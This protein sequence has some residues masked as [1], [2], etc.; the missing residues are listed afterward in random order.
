MRF[1]FV[2]GGIL[3][4]S[5]SVAVLAQD[6][7][8][9]IGFV[10]D[11]GTATAYR[12]NDVK[13]LCTPLVTEE[14]VHGSKG[15]DKACPDRI[16]GERVEVFGLFNRATNSIQAKRVE[17][18]HPK[19]LSVVGFALI[20]RV[21]Q[22]PANGTVLVRADGYPLS[23]TAAT[24]LSY[25]GNLKHSLVSAQTNTWIRY[26]GIL[27]SDG[28]VT[29]NTAALFPNVIDKREEDLRT[30]NEFDA[31]GVREEQR[32]GSMNKF[33]RGLNGKRIPAYDDEEMQQRIRSIGE[34]LV[35]AYQRALPADDPSKI[36]FRFQLVD[37]PKLNDELS[38]PNG[39][40]LMPYQV[41]TR[42]GDSDSRVAAVLASGIAEVLGKQAL[43]QASAFRGIQATELIGDGLGFI[44]PGA[45][46]VTGIAGYGSAKTVK[47]HGVEQSDR[48]ALALMHDA[49]FDLG[50]APLAWW[51]LAERSG[52][53]LA[54][55]GLPERTTDDYGIL[56]RVWGGQSAPVAIDATPAN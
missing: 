5:A 49:G 21:L 14:V 46:I 27:R 31:A 36:N 16:L 37:Q 41:L 26:R 18:E 24:T 53:T 51:T 25:A 47:R 30:R 2:A 28:I 52:Q 20:D 15:G 38:F 42:L 54:E 45:S 32:Q 50:Q 43:R 39:I 13:V 12:V 6:S 7:P 34:R 3:A 40:I 1:A 35:P 55:T 22:A 29:A 8:A 9:L 4:I 56:A 17:S 48:V 44:V 19:D 23:L 33:F 10:T 11:T